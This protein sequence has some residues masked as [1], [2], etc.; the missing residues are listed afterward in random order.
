ML[1]QKIIKM[2]KQEINSGHCLICENEA[3]QLRK[4][5]DLCYPKTLFNIGKEFG[6]NS[7]KI[8]LVFVG[9]SDWNTKEE[10]KNEAKPIFIIRGKPF[11]NGL[12]MGKD[13]F[14]KPSFFWRYIRDIIQSKK[15]NLTLDDYAISN[16]GKCNIYNK[17]NTN[18]REDTDYIYYHNCNKIFEK[19]MQIL[20]PSHIIFFTGSEFDDL[21][22]G[23]RFWF[24]DSY[25]YYQDI[26]DRDYVERITYRN[27]VQK[28]NR[29]AC[30]WHR[31]FYSN[32]NREKPELQFLRI[33][34]PQGMP[35]EFKEKIIEWLVENK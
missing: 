1:E 33:R 18:Y 30:W 6:Q 15:L 16:L 24:N 5:K 14:D 9:K 4:G 21:L 13:W 11:Y 29:T 2:Y 23:L 20:Q 8:R 12:Y 3:K 17:K 27:D 28:K 7:D 35:D 22:N 25:W 34:H 31:I 32:S 19:E 26:K 10:L